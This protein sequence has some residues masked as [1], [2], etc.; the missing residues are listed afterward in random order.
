LLCSRTTGLRTFLRALIPVSA[1]TITMLAG[2]SVAHAAPSKADLERQIAE[3]STQLEKIVEQYN[4]LNV[5]LTKTRADIAKLT[6]ELG[7]LEQQADEA[8]AAVA[9]IASTAYRSGSLSGWNAL[10]AGG[11]GKVVIER[12]GTLDHLAQSQQKQV[13]NARQASAKQ[14]AVADALNEQL[15][16]ESARVKAIIGQRK[17]IE[18]DLAKLEALKKEAYPTRAV[19]ATGSKYTGAIPKISGKAGTAVAYA[20]RALGKPYI[21]A[22]E[23]PKG[24]DCSGLTLA[25][26]R[27][28]GVSLYHHA[29]TQWDQVAHIKR[30][31]LAPGDLV[32]YSGLG[33]VGLYV[34][35]S[36][37]IHAPTFGD[38]VKISSVDMMTP[39][40]YGRVRS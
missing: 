32:F 23:G 13:N 26:W 28:A 34:G 10:L 9:E 8:K 24:Y 19:N 29:A 4:K 7:P 37:V 12:L 40:G 25:A 22:A 33:H 14:R 36:K 35:S 20:Y 27:A 18:A 21:W 15:A 17:G 6:Q 3:K 16:A 1:L 30:S 31:Q 39:Y 11:D 2:N 38:V 5:Q